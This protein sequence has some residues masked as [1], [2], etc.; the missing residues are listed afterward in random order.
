M[1]TCLIYKESQTCYN[2]PEH[3]RQE[4]SAI[5][6]T[7]SFITWGSFSQ[8]EDTEGGSS[9]DLIIQSLLGMQYSHSLSSISWDDSFLDGSVQ[10][11]CCTCAYT[12]FERWRS[13]SKFH[14]SLILR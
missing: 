3:N 8:F 4:T 13:H 5:D 14:R 9:I 2:D 12:L 1:S 10:P 7:S 11:A 6:G